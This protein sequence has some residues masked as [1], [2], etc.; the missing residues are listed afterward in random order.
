MKA[1][2]ES[3]SI[4]SGVDHLRDLKSSR[5]WLVWKYLS[6]KNGK[7]KK[8]AVSPTTL[9]A[10]GFSWNDP[11]NWI[12]YDEA[13]QIKKRRAVDG[14]GFVPTEDDPYAF[15][16]F[17]HVI[18][19]DTGELLKPWVF[20][21]IQEVGSYTEKS[22]SDAGIRTIIKAKMKTPKGN[23]SLDGNVF[24]VYDKNQ[25]LSIT[26]KV[27][28]DAPVQDGQDLIDRLISHS[29]PRYKKTTHL[30]EVELS[31]DLEDIRKKIKRLLNTYDLPS[32]PI[33][34]GGRKVTLLSVGGA[35]WKNARMSEE[36]FWI[37]LNEV[38]STL[39]YNSEGDLEGL[40]DEELQE[41]F[42]KITEMDVITSEEDVQETIDKLREFL[43]YIK[44]RIKRPRTTDWDVVMGLCRHG[45]KYG[46]IV[47]G[48]LRIDCSWRELQKLSR[49][50]ASK[51]I[52]NSLIRLQ[53]MGVLTGKD[54]GDRSG[55]FI[56]DLEKITDLDS[57]YQ[58]PCDIREQWQKESSVMEGGDKDNKDKNPSNT[59]PPTHYTASPSARSLQIVSLLAQ[60]SWH[61]GLGPTKLSYVSAYIFLGGEASRSEVADITGRS[62]TT[63][64]KMNK[65]LE[66]D[67]I[68]ENAGWG[69]YKLNL[70][71]IP[72][73]IY[74][75]RVNKGE[76]IMDQKMKERVKQA[77]KRYA[78][79]A[80]VF[81]HQ[82]GT[83]AEHKRR[84]E[85]FRRLIANPDKS[86]PDKSEGVTEY[87]EGINTGG[88]K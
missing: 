6:V 1:S 35:I 21:L 59:Y 88:W 60:T 27:Y 66:E 58:Q 43:I 11:D 5:Q 37:F 41:V 12:S 3:T 44:P 45:R 48:K 78:D 85:P 31:G 26:E 40:D 53:R 14:M 54:V 29:T 87:E 80:Q 22:P 68:L 52:R 61:R 39:L 76:F 67:G 57:W 69:R 17:D 28:L 50:S 25:W 4:H 2:G 42:D 75:F 51:T 64:S 15:L 86:A 83:R 74:D 33:Q 24:E 71:D 9:M 55:H 84:S 63:V 82:K 30:P 73:K 56:V 20:D 81:V 8:R 10:T 18:D 23:H 72:E 62:P 36:E 16:D 70:E 65:Q 47:R 7:L 46:R 34:E 19:L 79:Y 38:N 49:K 32:D 77:R 13:I